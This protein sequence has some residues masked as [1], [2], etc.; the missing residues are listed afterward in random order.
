MDRTSGRMT[1]SRRTT[2]M[3]VIMSMAISG[4]SVV[5]LS[6]SIVVVTSVSIVHG[7][8]LIM[9]RAVPDSIMPLVLM[10]V[11]NG[12]MVVVF[13]VA[14]VVEPQVMVMRTVKTIMGMI[15]PEH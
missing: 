13:P 9:T 2:V 10:N 15:R 5:I 1:N 14:P 6:P 3:H 12:P 7:A 11:P 8:N 4:S